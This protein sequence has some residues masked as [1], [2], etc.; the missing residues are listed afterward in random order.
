VA[1]YS[2]MAVIIVTHALHHTALLPS[3]VPMVVYDILCILSYFSLQHIIPWP[4]Q[5]EATL[6]SMSRYV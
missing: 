4:T 3:T 5:L 6:A 2:T 1:V